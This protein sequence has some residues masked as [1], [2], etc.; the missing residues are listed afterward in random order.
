MHVKRHRHR[1]PSS[2]RGM[3][4]G[5]HTVDLTQNRQPSSFNSKPRTDNYSDEISISSRF[6]LILFQ[7]C[8]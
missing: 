8:S 7:L 1:D 3:P 6:Y 4:T 5:I 2:L